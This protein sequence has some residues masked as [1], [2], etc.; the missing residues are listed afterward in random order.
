MTNPKTNYIRGDDHKWYRAFLESWRTVP[1]WYT[2]DHDILLLELVLRNGL[3]CNKLLD[4][5]E[6]DKMVE[7]KLRLRCDERNTKMDPYYEFKRWC[8][9]AFNITSIKIC[10]KCDCDQFRR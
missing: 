2:Y 1:E 7:Y 6:G 9:I 8:T 10:N 4:D 3:D 5:L